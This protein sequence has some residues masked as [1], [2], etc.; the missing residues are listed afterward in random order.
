MLS[1]EKGG[2]CKEVIKCA[3]HSVILTTPS[4]ERIE[5]EGIQPTPKEYENDLF[6]GVYTEDGKVGHEF[7]KVDVEEQTS[8]E[9]INK[10]D[11]HA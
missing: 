9:E 7:S 4:E 10:I 1:L 6:K 11:D 2:Y 5:Y 3:Q 8:L